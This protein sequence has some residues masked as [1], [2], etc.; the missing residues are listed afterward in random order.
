M[1]I[2]EKI[3]ASNQTLVELVA[4]I[5]PVALVAGI[6]GVFVVS[7]KLKF[8]ISLLLGAV[9]AAL[10]VI[11]MYVTIDRE[12]DMPDEDAGKYAK[13]NYVLRLIFMVLV[14]LCGLKLPFLHFPG[15]FL[16]LLTL[17]VSV[18]IRPLTRK[19][20]LKNKQEKEGE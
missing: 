6:A 1:N 10:L 19:Y 7:E 2:R 17:K 9:C 20:I 18:Y 12:L 4:G 16:G 13:R 5:P 8:C 14:V 11:H 15:L 3:R